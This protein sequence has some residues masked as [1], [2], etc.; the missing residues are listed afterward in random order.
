MK[1]VAVVNNQISDCFYASNPLLSS[2]SLWAE[3][4]TVIGFLKAA[5]SPNSYITLHKKEDIGHV[6]VASNSPTGLGL[7]KPISKPSAAPNTS[8]QSTPHSIDALEFFRFF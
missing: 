8:Q 2:S 4:K 1:E 6:P 3:L 5:R 7:L